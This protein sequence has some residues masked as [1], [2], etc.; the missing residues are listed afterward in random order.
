MVEGAAAE[1]QVTTVKCADPGMWG[2]GNLD[3]P[4]CLTQQFGILCPDFWYHGQMWAHQ[5]HMRSCLS[6]FYNGWP[7]C[8]LFLEHIFCNM[9]PLLNHLGIVLLICSWTH[10]GMQQLQ[11]LGGYLGI[12]FS[13]TCL[14]MDRG[15]LHT[16]RQ[17]RFHLDPYTGSKLYERLLYSLLHI[18]DA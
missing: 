11:Q 1:G 2:A 7:S 16:T 13:Q 3:F 18:P 10:A 14:L 9:A 12:G 6:M 5:F 17:H 4:D 15:C 8:L